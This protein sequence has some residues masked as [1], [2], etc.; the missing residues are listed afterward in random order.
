M[1]GGQTT[2]EV[3]D[4]VIVG[5]GTAG[6]LLAERLTANPTTSVCLIEAGPRDL[7]P[8]IHLPA[9]YIKMLFNPAYTWQ[10][11][12]EP[13]EGSG[14]RRIATTQGRM[15]GGSSSLNGL[16]YNRGQAADFD[17]WAQMGN[18]GWGYEDLLPLFRQTERR[19]GD[20]DDALRGRKGGLPVTDLDWH[21]PLCDAFVQGAETLGIPR[22]PDYNG[23]DQAGVGY[24]QRVIH[25]GLRHSS[26]RAFL[27]A[28]R[29]RAN[30]QL[31]TG[32]QVARITFDGRRATGVIAHNP[33]GS[34]RPIAARREVIVA[35]GAINS[36]KLLQ[37][38][39]IGPADLLADLGL[40]P[41]V[42]RAGVGA[43]LRDHWAV[44]VVARVRGIRTINRMVTGL[45]L[46]GQA[47]RWVTGRPNVLGVS[48]SLAHVFWKSRPDVPGTDLQLTFTP[49]SYRAGVA[50]LLD[51]FDGMT[52]GVWQQRPESLGHVR[53]KSA[54]A[55]Q[56]PLIQ[57]NYLSA[58]ADRR[59][60]VGGV[61]LARALLETPALR[62][63][64]DGHESPGP[65]VGTDDEILDF[66]RRNGSTV[67]HLM[68]SCRMGPA[69]D[70]MAVVDDR[71]RV[72]GVGGLRVID[73]SIM[74]TM[75]SANT[76]AA[77][78]VIAEMGADAILRG[79]D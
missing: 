13:S 16:V 26:A 49:A 60:M 5:A 32:T 51:S 6:C 75:P 64:F 48:P 14:G 18:R 2:A 63:W 11:T 7:H 62:P 72:H 39:G 55:R 27:S 25:R 74:P 41:V 21:H 47:L 38:S 76:M 73:S 71:L 3:F 45:P 33:D 22:N 34:D 78:Y 15:L 12:T 50:G 59:A 67:F 28:S 20:G 61:R 29:R 57:P 4:Y 1:D 68:G 31:L 46:M 8:F 10:F 9:G 56:V 30:L 23:A 19:I 40:A 24:Y 36:P 70:P 35:A 54:D 69:G 79:L 65:E 43:N 53:A 44:R 17:S 52:C 58:E 42:V 37:I 77:T 66:A